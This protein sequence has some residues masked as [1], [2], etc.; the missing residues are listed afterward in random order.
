MARERHRK[1]WM[2]TAVT[3]LLV[4]VIGDGLPEC[5]A[6]LDH[7]VQIRRIG[8]SGRQSDSAAAAHLLRAGQAQQLLQQ[9]LQPVQLGGH[10]AV[11]RPALLGHVVLEGV[12]TQTDCGQRIAQLVRGIGDEAPLPL[13]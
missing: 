11:R 1:P 5:D 9:I 7:V 12:R 4:L 2:V 6:L 10:R 3:Q 8:D 13:E